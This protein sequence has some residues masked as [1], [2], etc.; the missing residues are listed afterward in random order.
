MFDPTLAMSTPACVQIMCANFGFE[1]A[2]LLRSNVGDQGL[3]LLIAGVLYSKGDVQCARVLRVA[4][5]ALLYARFSGN[6]APS[7]AEA[8]WAGCRDTRKPIAGGGCN[9]I[10]EHGVDGWGKTGFNSFMRRRIG[11]V[12]FSEGF[13]RR[14]W[15]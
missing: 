5:Q 10:G 4:R 3:L 1:A 8:D 13:R 7:A 6:N 2:F 15:G 14:C 12:R 11:V 9:N